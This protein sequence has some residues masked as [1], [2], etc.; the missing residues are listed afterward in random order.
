MNDF[1]Q[2]KNGNLIE[3]YFISIESM[4]GTNWWEWFVFM[5]IIMS[6][7]SL[8]ILL[9]NGIFVSFWIRNSVR[10]RTH[11]SSGKVSTRS[12]VWTLNLPSMIHLH[13]MLSVI[14]SRHSRVS[15]LRITNNVS[16]TS[17]RQL[18]LDYELRD[19]FSNYRRRLRRILDPSMIH[20]HQMLGFRC[21]RRLE[22]FKSFWEAHTEGTQNV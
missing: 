6:C 8:F 1:W 21:F 15:R 18:A 7:E 4:Y 17:M 20:L 10:R 14:F 3:T 5:G 19:A 2:W 9:D 16:I 12:R 13:Q 22:V 11:D